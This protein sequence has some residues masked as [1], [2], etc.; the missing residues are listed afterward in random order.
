LSDRTAIVTDYFEPLY[1]GMYMNVYIALDDTDWEEFSADRGPE[2]RFGYT[3][4]FEDEESE[5]GTSIAF[6][7]WLIS[8]QTEHL[9]TGEFNDY[10]KA[11]EYRLN[12]H[13]TLFDDYD[14]EERI[15]IV[16]NLL[17]DRGPGSMHLLNDVQLK[18]IDDC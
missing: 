17:Y 10:L 2:T 6:Y 12:N 4:P 18:A 8:R 9:D 7:P 14:E 3:L 15:R 16:D 5:S 1:R 11:V 13:I